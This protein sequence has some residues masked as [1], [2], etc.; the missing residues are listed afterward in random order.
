MTTEVEVVST[1]RT[2]LVVLV[3]PWTTMVVVEVMKLLVGEGAAIIALLESHDQ[4]WQACGAY[5][6]RCRPSACGR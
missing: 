5:L 3:V 2:V 4:R 1:V 6:S